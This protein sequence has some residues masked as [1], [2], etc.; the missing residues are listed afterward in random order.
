MENGDKDQDEDSVDIHGLYSKVIADFRARLLRWLEQ[1]PE[2]SE[3]QD[4]EDREVDA[5]LLKV[6]PGAHCT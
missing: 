1:E 5:L 3:I 6:S 2:S 4:H